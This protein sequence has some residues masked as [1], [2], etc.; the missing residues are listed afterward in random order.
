MQCSRAELD[1]VARLI[2]GAG[3]L[4]GVSQGAGNA[5][6]AAVRKFALFN[7]ESHAAQ[8]GTETTHAT[9][10]L[11]SSALTKLG[12]SGHKRNVAVLSLQNYESKGLILL[13]AKKSDYA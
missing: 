1:L 5:V 3:S 6:V 4:K 10:R 13:V 7:G 2:L 9:R 8:Y 11:V 12:G